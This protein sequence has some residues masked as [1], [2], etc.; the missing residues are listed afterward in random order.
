MISASND[1]DRMNNQF[2]VCD[3]QHSVKAKF[4]LIVEGDLNRYQAAI[5]GIIRHRWSLN[6][7]YNVQR[8][9][10]IWAVPIGAGH[11]RQWVYTNT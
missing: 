5:T 8:T 7:S 2:K 3:Q 10:I 9:A 11:L 4:I 6:T 1:T